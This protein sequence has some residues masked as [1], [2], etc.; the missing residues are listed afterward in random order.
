MIMKNE[1]QFSDGQGYA[2]RF[3]RKDQRFCQIPHDFRIGQTVAHCALF[4]FAVACLAL[5]GCVGTS[6]KP[7]VGA[8]ATTNI[9]GVAQT[10]VASLTVSNGMYLDATVTNDKQLLGVDWTVS[11]GSELPVGTPLP[12]GE[13]I[14]TSCG[15]FTPAHTASAPVPSYATTGTGIVTY[16]TA[17]AAPPTGGTV[18]LYAKSTSDPSRFSSLVLSVDGLPITIAIVASSASPY[19]L[20]VNGTISLTGVL[21]NDYTVGGGS[22]NW[23]VTC[24]SSACGSFSATK[25]LTGVATTYTA[26]ATVP[27]PTDTVTITATSV[28]DSTKSTTAT[29]TIL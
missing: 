16:Y 23:M 4:P 19:S 18:T 6:V 20:D 27:S 17:P 29:I 5:S 11:C 26:P 1:K 15:Y 3:T 14:D 25:T 9:D 21:S 7:Q 2:D 10:S 22:V 12:T 13:T 24:S 8:I 28:T